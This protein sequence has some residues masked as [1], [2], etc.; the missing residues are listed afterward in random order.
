MPPPKLPEAATFKVGHA[1]CSS[2]MLAS[3][4]IQAS[5]GDFVCREP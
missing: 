5:D 1:D 4:A 2:I 3:F